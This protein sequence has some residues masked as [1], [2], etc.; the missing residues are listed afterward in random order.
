MS[1]RTERLS[2]SFVYLSFCSLVF[3]IRFK[4]KIT[5]TNVKSL[6]PNF[7]FKSFRI[8]VLHS[9]LYPESI[10]VSSNRFFGGL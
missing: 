1:D 8:Q 2:L 4:K 9:I 3:E 7:S 6:L 10:F 5:K